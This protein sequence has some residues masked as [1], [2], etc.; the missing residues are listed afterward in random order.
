[1]TVVWN[2]LREEFFEI[3]LHY[4]QKR[5]NKQG[6]HRHQ[7]SCNLFVFTAKLFVYRNIGFTIRTFPDVC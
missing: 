1:V 5:G 6:L 4:G 3:Q 7:S 2:D